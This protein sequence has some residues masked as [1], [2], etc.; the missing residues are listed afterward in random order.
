M[1]R[2]HTDLQC[3]W[4]SHLSL[5][6]LLWLKHF[7]WAKHAFWCN[8]GTGPV[9][10]T[11][12]TQMGEVSADHRP[13]IVSYRKHKGEAFQEA[14]G[15]SKAWWRQSLK[16]SGT[17][18]SLVSGLYPA[19]PQFCSCTSVTEIHQTPW[20]LKL[21]SYQKSF[22][23]K[24]TLIYIITLPHLKIYKSKLKSMPYFF[25]HIM[26]TSHMSNQPHTSPSSPT[27]AFPLSKP[28]HHGFCHLPTLYC[29]TIAQ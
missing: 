16:T 7:T 25:P 11:L 24:M 22:Y 23:T 15:G 13:A 12:P 9:G 14:P 8:G 6:Q 20:F 29:S 27:P 19:S 26:L 3:F 5:W 1:L 10:I 28:K 17:G 18:C 21:R 4:K 2:S